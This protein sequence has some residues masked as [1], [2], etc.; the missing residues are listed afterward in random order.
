MQVDGDKVRVKFR[1]IGGGLAAKGDVLKGFA[2][3]AE[4]KKFVWAEAKIDGG[5]VLVWSKD[6]P[7]PMHVRYGWADNPDCNL[8]NKEGLPAA[9]FRTDR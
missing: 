8:Y 5:S 3:A 4:D 2:V 7:K 6:V 1:H 9:P